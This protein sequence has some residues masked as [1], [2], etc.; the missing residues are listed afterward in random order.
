VR[1]GDLEMGPDE[2]EHRGQAVKEKIL[3]SSSGERALSSCS[4]PWRYWRVEGKEWKAN[5]NEKHKAS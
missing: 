2:I 3:V 5:G 1:S 4:L